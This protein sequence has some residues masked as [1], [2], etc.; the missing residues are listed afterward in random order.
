MKARLWRDLP[1]VAY[2]GLSVLASWTAVTALTPA[3]VE[4]AATAIFPLAAIVAVSRFGWRAFEPE[5][6]RFRVRLAAGVAALLAVIVLAAPRTPLAEA[7]IVRV[8]EAFSLGLTLL[9]AGHAAW[10][11]RRYVALY[12]GP[13]AMY[14]IVL[15]N[16]GI[17]AGFFREPG[18]GFYVGS[19]PAPLA[20][21]AGWVN[22]FYLCNWMADDVRSR[23]T[24]VRRGAARSALTATAAAL[25][26]DLQVD[27]LATAAGLWQWHAKLGEDWLGVPLLNY[28]AWA[29]AVM[30]FAWV[31][32]RAPSQPAAAPW[33]LRRLPLA[34]LLATAMFL[35]SMAVLEGGLHGPTYQILA[36]TLHETLA[37]FL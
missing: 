21:M 20:T 10:R 1:L 30:P 4:L 15:E 18:Y 3:R 5:E 33:L 28:V 13:V 29:C 14:G 32:Y 7:D 11:G 23:S 31:M 6:R 16:G 27:P 9:I 19:L 26:L 2:A 37:A 34:L 36:T 25:A 24:G 17:L 8:H 35:V 12:F 22:V